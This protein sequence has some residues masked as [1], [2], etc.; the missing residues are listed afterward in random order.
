MTQ[1]CEWDM[2]KKGKLFM[3]VARDN[4]MEQFC[5]V[6]DQGDKGAI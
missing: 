6:S 2:T 4:D 5:L 1:D 3:M